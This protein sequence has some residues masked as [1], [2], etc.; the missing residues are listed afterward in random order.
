MPARIGASLAVVAIGQC[1]RLAS[2]NFKRS[3]RQQGLR[4]HAMRCP[5]SPNRPSPI[6]P[7]TKRTSSNRAAK[8]IKDV[9][10]RFIVR[11]T[12]VTSLTGEPPKR[13]VVLGFESIDEV[14]KWQGGEYAKLIPIRDQIGKWR[15]FAVPTC[16]NPQGAKPG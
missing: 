14:K 11:T 6:R 12:E 16:E 10:G 9:G 7:N 2:P 13:V 3:H 8:T 1:S 15:S 5:S 4:R